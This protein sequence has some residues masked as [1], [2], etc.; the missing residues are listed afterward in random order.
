LRG[1]T[2]HPSNALDR[3]REHAWQLPWLRL[4]LTAR[5]LLKIPVGS[6]AWPAAKRALEECAELRR[7]M[8]EM[9]SFN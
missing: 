7:R 1:S 4:G 3:L 2:I 6:Y 5:D 9:G 8:I